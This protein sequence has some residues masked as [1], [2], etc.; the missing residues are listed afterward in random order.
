MPMLG[1]V[2]TITCMVFVLQVHA[3]LGSGR[4]QD[5]DDVH[6]AVIMA[7]QQ[8]EAAEAAAAAD[9]Q[10]V[11]D[12]LAAAAAAADQPHKA[13]DKDICSQAPHLR[14]VEIPAAQGADTQPALAGHAPSTEVF[15]P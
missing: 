12:A 1:E 10:A 8:L 7:R 2:Q 11:A 3:R 14:P 9:R 6:Q 4:R 5:G 15:K 13:Q